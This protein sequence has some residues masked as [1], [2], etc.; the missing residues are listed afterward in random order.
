MY[1]AFSSVPQLMGRI[2]GFYFQGST[3]PMIKKFLWN[4]EIFQ[5]CFYITRLPVYREVPKNIHSEKGIFR[6]EG[7]H[8]WM[9][10]LKISRCSSSHRQHIT[11]NNVLVPVLTTRS[12]SSIARQSRYLRSDTV[13]ALSRQFQTDREQF[14]SDPRLLLLEGFPS[15]ITQTPCDAVILSLH[16][17][18]ATCLTEERK[19]TTRSAGDD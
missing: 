13:H 12:W 4:I 7:R 1:S 10:S 14:P 17:C 19:F 9:S 6:S 15:F 3:L 11:R 8:P 18:R 5:G 2:G 16:R